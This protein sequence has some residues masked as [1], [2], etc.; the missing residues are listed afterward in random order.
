[1]R[2]PNRM[3]GAAVV[4][5]TVFVPACSKSPVDKVGTAGA[6]SEAPVPTLPW[7]HP[8]K[9]EIGKTAGIS[10]P[11]SVADFRSTSVT[12]SELDVA[13]T[14]AAADVAAFDTDSGLGLTADTRVVGHASP[15]WGADV[16]GTV[17]GSASERGGYR[18]AVEVISDPASP[19]VATVR[20]AITP[21]VSKK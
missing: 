1:M 3:A 7:T 15:L 10:F 6:S 21:A 11:A 20:M 5:A 9:S 12:P 17:S 14:I 19:E 4:L 18:R 13:F 8:S 2:R 16:T